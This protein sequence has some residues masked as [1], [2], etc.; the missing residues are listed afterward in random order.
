[1]MYD[2]AIQ[3]KH[4]CTFA[5]VSKQY[6]TCQPLK[7]LEHVQI[8][9]ITRSDYQDWFEMAQQLW[10][11]YD[12][13]AIEIALTN[14]QKSPVEAAYLLRNDKLA[15]GFI[16]LSLR[17]DHIPGATQKPVAYIEGVFV[18][19]EFRQHG[20]GRM[21]VQQAEEWAIKQGCAELTSDVTTDNLPSQEFHRQVGFDDASRVVSFIKTL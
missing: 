8:N 7:R 12:A 11:D 15:V 19:D 21:L 4:D 6:F 1:M 18:R 5:G 2:S 16:N 20:F 10:P 3:A 17:Y 9:E 13:D 14:A